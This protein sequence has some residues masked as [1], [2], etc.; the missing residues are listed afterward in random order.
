MQKTVINDKNTLLIGVLPP[1][2]LLTRLLPYPPKA[3]IPMNRPPKMFA[4]PKATNSR[5]AETFMLTMP[6]ASSYSLP[7]LSIF[8]SILAVLLARDFAATLDSKKPRSAMRKEVE[9]ASV[10]CSIM[11][12]WKGK[13][14]WKGLPVVLRSPRISRPC[15]SQEKPQVKRAEKTTT[16]NRSG[17]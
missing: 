3:G 10:T 16:R 6:S 11:E 2:L 7:S 4:T 14:T 1:V 9:K 12:G 13:C 17:K 15:L 8:F 5:L